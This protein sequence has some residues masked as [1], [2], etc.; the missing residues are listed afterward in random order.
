MNNDFDDIDTPADDAALFADAESGA[1][2][3]LRAKA[4]DEADEE[5]GE[6]SCSEVVAEDKPDAEVEASAE[7]QRDAVIPRPRF[8]EVN[9]KYKQE[10]ERADELERQLREATAGKAEANQE[11]P[12]PAFDFDAKEDEL[13]TA[14]MDGDMD[15]VRAIR[16]EIKDAERVERD[17]L[18]Q[19]ATAR[20][21]RQATEV[22][23]QRE[24]QRLLTEA[25]QII[26]TKYPGLNDNDGDN[27]AMKE[28]LEWRDFNFMKGMSAHEAL[29]KAAERVAPAYFKEGAAPAAV[30]KRKQD[31]VVRN[32]RDAAAQP[33]A[34]EAGIGNR[35]APPEPEISTQED[36]EK[37]P[38]KERER[39]LA[40]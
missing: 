20:A 29:L 26:V 16:K 15:R 23:T 27:P 3:G 2:E 8:D 13:E 6:E 35:A 22:V 21:E 5:Q 32:L 14:R 33:A 30:D 4:G 18:F 38:A 28:I 40:S 1:D 12:P 36:W 9:A 19:E 34:P 10:K 39:L 37:L 25:A 11:P 7:P 17:R 31:A 24:Q